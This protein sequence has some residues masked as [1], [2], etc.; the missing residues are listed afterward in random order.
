MTIGT[1]QGTVTQAIDPPRDATA[2]SVD[3][4]QQSSPERTGAAQTGQFEPMS[5]VTPG[6]GLVQCPEVVA[7]DHALRELLEPRLR[8]HVAQFR[9]ADQNDL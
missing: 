7:R 2:V 8:E 9:L 4:A 6:I 1:E 5:H 3:A